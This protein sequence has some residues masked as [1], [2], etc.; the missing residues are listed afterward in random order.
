MTLPKISVVCL[1]CLALLGTA[2]AFDDKQDKEKEKEENTRS[3][4]GAVYDPSENPAGS[5][6]VQLKNTANLQVRSYITKDDG[7]YQFQGLNI[8]VNY[9]I[10]AVRGAMSSSV[11]TLSIFDSRKKA[12]I[13]L[14]L[15]AKK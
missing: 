15:E 14:R 3:L 7:R 13:N 9:E 11:R 8:N 12:V 5:A 6:I 4:Q 10:K 1:V 2:F